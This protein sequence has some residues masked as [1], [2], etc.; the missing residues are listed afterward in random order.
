MD[1][2]GIATMFKALGDPTRLRIYT[3]LADCPYPVAVEDGGDVRPVDGP[4]VGEICCHVLGSPQ[5]S[6]NISFHLKELRNAGL[7]TTEKRGKHVV[8]GVDN[9]AQET[10]RGFFLN[11]RKDAPDCC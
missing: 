3:F 10:L 5:S 1:H 8:C 11:L 4:T 7:I 6:P 9:A 2:E